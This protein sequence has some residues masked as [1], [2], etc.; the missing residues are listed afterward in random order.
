MVRSWTYTNYTLTYCEYILTYGGH[1]LMGEPA[2][3]ADGF[4]E[5]CEGKQGVGDCSRTQAGSSLV[6]GTQ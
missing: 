5:E 6:L 1:T 4:M 2:G 3:F